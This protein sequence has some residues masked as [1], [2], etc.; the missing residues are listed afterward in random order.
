MTNSRAGFTLVELLI[1]VVLSAFM[2]GAAYQSLI[3]QERV[4][5]TTTEMVR[6]Q[7][8]LRTVVGIMESELGDLA[9]RGGA[10]I[11]AAD[12]L[13]ASPD[14]IRF[15]A[16]RAVGFLCAILPSEKRLAMW[17]PQPFTAVQDGDAVLIF[18]EGDP[19][20][21]TVDRWLIGRSYS[22]ETSTE[23]CPSSPTGTAEQKLNLS[24]LAGNALSSGFLDPVKLGSPVR[25]L[26]EVTY[27]LFSFDG[28]WGL[29]RL[30]RNATDPDEIL[31]GLDGPGYGLVFSYLDATLTPITTTPID[32][33]TIAAIEITVR[34]E[35]RGGADSKELSTTVFLRNNI[36]G[37][38]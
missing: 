14:S 19:T 32:P 23:G 30:S 21:G 18:A 16:G 7:D 28:R 4:S 29:G 11:G 17:S 31:V 1:V 37:T 22:V 26:R 15:R 3:T 12:I 2:M 13:M 25:I 20:L 6:G 5:R 34:S 35:A 33:T 27:G 9:T 10:G 36:G 38:P 8:A 24:D